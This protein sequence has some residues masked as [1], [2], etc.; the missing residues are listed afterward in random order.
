ME[1]IDNN[2]FDTIYQEHFSYFSLHTVKGIFEKNGLKVFDVETLKTHG[3][4]LRVFAAHVED[5]AKDVSARV[6]DLLSLEQNKGML[7]MEYY[8]GFSRKAEK[9]RSDIMD[10]LSR[11]KKA[12]KRIVAYGA[13]AKGNTLLNY[14]GISRDSIDF[15]VDASEHKQGK[16]LP[17][18]HIPVVSEERI[19]QTRPNFILI[20]PWN[21][22]DE[23]TQQLA[24]VRQ[25]GA[26]FVIPIPSLEVF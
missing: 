9:V 6:R 14:C 24:Y 20:L 23:I 19:G 8:Q 10:F 13:A 12:G 17:G 26:R 4:S 22:K 15:V 11:E 21:L 18:S 16:F 2:Q 25:W 7:S 3:G 5:K 1:L